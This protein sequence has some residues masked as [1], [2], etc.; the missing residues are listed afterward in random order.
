ME[1]NPM[2]R[3]FCHSD[4]LSEG[5]STWSSEE[6]PQGRAEAV[7][8]R[9]ASGKTLTNLMAVG[10]LEIKVVECGWQWV[11]TLGQAIYLDPSEIRVSPAD[12]SGCK[13]HSDVRQIQSRAQNLRW[14][15]TN[16]TN[17]PFYGK[18]SCE[19]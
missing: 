6:D 8:K 17:V 12:R 11:A 18:S 15:F 7:P 16:A 2:E 4:T 13:R 5:T 10:F 19:W 14:D 9:A 1:L 3:I